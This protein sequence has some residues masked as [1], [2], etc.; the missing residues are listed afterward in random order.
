MV[1]AITATLH[2]PVVLR[3]T[4]AAVILTALIALLYLVGAPVYYGG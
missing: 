2:R 1:A 3:V 4:Q